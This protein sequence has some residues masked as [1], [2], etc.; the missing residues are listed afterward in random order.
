MKTIE[1]T[2]VKSLIGRKPNQI[3]TAKAL[4]LTKINQT[5][6]KEANEAI[7]GMVNTIKHLVKVTEKQ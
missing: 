3:A 1:I 6:E 4:G 5:V 2:L 7:L